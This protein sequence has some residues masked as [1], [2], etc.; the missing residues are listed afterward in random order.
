MQT[1]YQ[2]DGMTCGGCA[3]SVTNALTKVLPN[4]KIDVSLDD[5]SATV[6]GEHIADVVKHAVEDAGFDFG[7]ARS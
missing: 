6:H 3:K 7:G 1:T 4:A 5:N 2:I